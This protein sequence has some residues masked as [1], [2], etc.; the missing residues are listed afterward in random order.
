MTASAI[1]G[2]REKC[3]RAGMDDYL[4][5]PV[6]SKTLERMLVRWSLSKRQ[7]G[8]LTDASRWS[9]SDCSEAV[10]QCSITDRP[11]PEKEEEDG[12]GSLLPECELPGIS[13]PSTI[14]PP[15]LK[16]ENLKGPE[17]SPW[18][19]SPV[20]ADS[21]ASRNREAAE[22][23][24]HLQSEKL[25]DAAGAGTDTSSRKTLREP[26]AGHALTEANVEKLEKGGG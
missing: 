1:Q 14:T 4:A 9:M 10:E 26:S 3:T 22:L 21:A 2:D 13:P 17:L 19:S 15:P 18:D 11:T 24:L 16:L 8:S 25:M 12:G 5:K 23:A 7:R 20:L 6:K